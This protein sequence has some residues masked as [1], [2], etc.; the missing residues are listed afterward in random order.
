MYFV[1]LQI[2]HIQL[3]EHFRQRE[4][5]FIK[6][7]D[8]ISKGQVDDN[9]IEFISQLE[10]P[11]PTTEFHL[12]PT[13]LQAEIHNAEIMS[14]LPGDFVVYKSIDSG[15]YYHNIYFTLLTEQY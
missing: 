1:Y 15:K 14:Q 11:L 6:V 3:T 5:M 9:V 7:I 10:R 4:E 8:K 12:Y 2:H 13:N